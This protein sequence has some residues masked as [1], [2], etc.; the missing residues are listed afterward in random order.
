MDPIVWSRLAS[1]D[2]VD[3]RGWKNELA[4]LSLS[5]LKAQTDVHRFARQDNVLRFAHDWKHWGAIR[6]GRDGMQRVSGRSRIRI[7]P[8]ESQ[9]HMHDSV[10]TTK[11]T[12]DKH[13]I[14]QVR[15]QRTSFGGGQVGSLR[16]LSRGAAHS[17][18]EIASIASIA[19]TE[20]ITG[21]TSHW[22]HMHRSTR[23]AF[24]DLSSPDGAFQWWQG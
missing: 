17:R 7:V 14:I 18:G 21:V 8:G 11:H 13:H 12:T 24:R 15:R 23:G 5:R 16:R 20:S 10:H 22:C 4:S 9:K 3:V 1:R 6:S 2:T 19:S